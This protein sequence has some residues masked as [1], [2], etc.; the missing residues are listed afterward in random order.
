[1]NLEVQNQLGLIQIFWKLFR[2]ISCIFYIFQDNLTHF[3]PQ[4]LIFTKNLTPK[5]EPRSSYK[6]E[7]TLH[8]GDWG[9]Q[10]GFQLPSIVMVTCKNV[11]SS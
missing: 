4:F 3:S 11:S 7:R 1:M 10:L 6:K 9:E 8:G 5:F 2:E